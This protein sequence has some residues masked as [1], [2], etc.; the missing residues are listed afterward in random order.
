[1]ESWRIGSFKKLESFFIDNLL[2]ILEK[3]PVENGNIGKF[4]PNLFSK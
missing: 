4:S 2:S 1:M 3:L